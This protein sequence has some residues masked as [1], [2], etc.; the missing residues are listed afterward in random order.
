MAKLFPGLVN[1][2]QSSDKVMNRPYFSLNKFFETEK[3]YDS[4]KE[5]K[6][7]YEEEIRTWLE[8]IKGSTVQGKN[9]PYSNPKLC[10]NN[11]QSLWLMP[12]VNSCIAISKLLEGDSYFLNMK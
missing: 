3:D 1:S 12:S 6:F 11:K 7:I 10:Q 5:C 8:I 4:S 2:V 9:F